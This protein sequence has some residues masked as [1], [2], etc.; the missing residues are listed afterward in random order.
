MQFLASFEQVGYLRMS[1]SIVCGARP[2]TIGA[3]GALY[4]VG[5]RAV[6]PELA[7]DGMS[8]ELMRC[9]RAEVTSA[10]R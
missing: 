1:E 8:N 9:N 4:V 7:K 3:I 10:W 2:L 6:V 5:V